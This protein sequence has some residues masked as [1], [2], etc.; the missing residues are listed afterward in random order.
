[1][2]PHE[3]ALVKRFKGRPFALLGVNR[4][5]GQ[6]RGRKAVQA[7]NLTWRNWV[8]FPGDSARNLLRWKVVFSPTYF[9]IDHKRIVRR[10]FV[11]KVEEADLADGIERLLKEAGKGKN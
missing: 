10:R 4:V 2:V 9:L 6:E 3:R 1:M 11:G 8:E 5:D 7:R